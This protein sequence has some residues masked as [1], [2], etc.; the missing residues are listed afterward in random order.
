MSLAGLLCL[1]GGARLCAQ[2]TYTISTYAGN[3]TRGF[4]GDGGAATAAQ[5]ALPSGIALDS[6]GNLVISDQFNQRIRQVTPGGASV[7]TIA[8]NGTAGFAGDGKAATAANLFNPFSVAVDS[9]G[10]VYIA[11]SG[12]HVVRK[13]SGGNINPYAG[14]NFLGPGFSGDGARA[15]D[16]QLDN[17]FGV[18]LDSTG[19]LYI[20]GIRNHRI[21]KVTTTG[22][23]TTYAGGNGGGAF[24]GEGVPAVNARLNQPRGLRVDAAGNLYFADSGNN[25]IRRVS[26]DGTIT[27]VAGT[28]TAGFAGDGGPATSAQLNR[29]LDVA[30]DGAGNLYIADY[31]NQ[32]IRR[33]GGNGIITTIAGNGRAAY[34][35]DG[36]PAASASLNFP[37][38]VV[39][40]GSGNVYVADNS[41][42][43]I[44][45]LTRAAGTLGVPT[46]N[47]VIGAGSYGAFTSVA[48]GSWIEIY[49]TNLGSTTRGW[50][51]ADFTGVNAPT[52]LEGTK[53]TIG[54]KAAF[55]DYVSPGQVNAQVP[56]DVTPGSQGIVVA[57]SIGVSASRSIT[58]NATQPGLFVPFVI[59]GRNFVGALFPDNVTYVAPTGAV[60]G[61]TS[62]PAR[63]GETIT[64]YGIGFGPVIPDTPAGQIVQGSNQLAATLQ[65]SFAGTPANLSYQ[66]LAPGAVG[67]YQFNLVVPSVAA[68]DAVPVT[69][70]LGGVAGTQ[71]LFTAV[72]N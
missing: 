31:N 22:T 55:V 25:R 35:G 34:A 71:Q 24:G 50:G 32:R 19:I 27:T 49:G 38:G 69:F 54:G 68:S 64:L 60:N 53:V 18:A 45:L 61:I 36:G 17:P 23:I 67:L 5:F 41:N 8:G 14:S 9:S 51:A 21:R 1:A 33:V 4:A 30:V 26:P 40:D 59:G 72:R 66:G 39:V 52:V 7:S 48:P 11:D 37:T 44:R 56:S 3:G 28:G 6:S 13:V 70:T 57:T 2:P 62:R 15:V 42:S 10:G 65:I 58:V 46:V 43:V 29:P 47:G 12:N 16:A 20:S 63:P